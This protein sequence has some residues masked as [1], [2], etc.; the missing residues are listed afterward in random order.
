MGR[1]L[2]AACT[3]MDGSRFGFDLFTRRARPLL[4]SSRAQS[5]AA[6]GST[7]TGSR[8]AGCHASPYR[9]RMVWCAKGLLQPRLETAALRLYERSA[10]VSELPAVVACFNV[11][12]WKYIPKLVMIREV[13]GVYYQLK[14]YLI[15][16][17]K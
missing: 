1:A 6:V 12:P 17:Q 14:A 13:I 10:Q 7:P 4:V 5:G 16:Q 9:T 3:R 15:T 2:Y 11:D 8:L